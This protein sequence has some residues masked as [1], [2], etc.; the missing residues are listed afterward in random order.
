M[1]PCVFATHSICEAQTL[2]DAMC[3]FNETFETKDNFTN[4][5]QQSACVNENKELEFSRET[6]ELFNDEEQ[7][8]QCAQQCTSQKGL[9][10]HGK[11]EKMQC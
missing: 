11:R 10:K 8:E 7:H 4:P 1:T 2:A 3:N 9:K 5:W 6:D